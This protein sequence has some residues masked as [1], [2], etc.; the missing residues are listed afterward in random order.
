MKIVSRQINIKRPRKYPFSQSW[1]A[2]SE[3]VGTGWATNEQVHKN[4]F[5]II[6][7]MN[8]HKNHVGCLSKA[9]K[10]SDQDL[11]NIRF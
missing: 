3:T 5:T 1:L 9:I 11:K 8:E 7:Q 2:S 4:Q 10:K 6:H